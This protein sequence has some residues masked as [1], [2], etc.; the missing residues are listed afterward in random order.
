MEESDP[1]KA[2][3]LLAAKETSSQSESWVKGQVAT[4]ERDHSLIPVGAHSVSFENELLFFV[5]AWFSDGQR[6]IFHVSHDALM[7]IITWRDEHNGAEEVLPAIL[8]ESFSAFYPTSTL[9]R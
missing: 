1:S 4:R 9:S 7:Q 8:C 2:F 6:R 3:F 5:F